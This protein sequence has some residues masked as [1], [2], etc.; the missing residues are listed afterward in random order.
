L[1]G[2]DDRPSPDD[3]RR[4][5]RLFGGRTAAWQR[6]VGR[7]YTP[8]ERWV[9]RSA[10]GRSAFAK[11]S[12]SAS[13]ADW[14]RDEYRAYE[15][16]EGDFMPRLYGFDDDG[17]T[18]ILLLEDLSQAHWPP[19]WDDHHV[20]RTLQTL[21]AVRRTGP[22]DG[23][24]ASPPWWQSVGGWPE[25]GKEPTS[26]LALGLCSERWLD[27][28]LPA[29]IAAA[30]RAVLEGDDLLHF[31][32][33]SDNVC[34]TEDR[35]LLVDWN[36]ACLGNGAL[37]VVGWIPSLLYEWGPQAAA[38]SPDEPELAALVTGY[39]AHH[40]RLPAIRDAPR[41]RSVQLAQVKTALPWTAGLLGLP[42]PDGRGLA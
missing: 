12:R 5:E 34:W 21:D 17:E 7:G 37:D 31:D 39:F 19:P 1:S 16:I 18:T 13:T 25:V 11:V 40:S 33:R 8:T 10:V 41:V 32:V 29:L 15:L 36:H 6:V 26:F 27:R 35:L 23:L 14:L 28:A 20:R 2:P 22:V 4:I 38:I 9:V 30:H 24:P 3:V 42:P